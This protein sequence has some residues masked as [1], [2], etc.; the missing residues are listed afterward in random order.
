MFINYIPISLA[1][2]DEVP[3]T[4]KHNQAYCFVTGVEPSQKERDIS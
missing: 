2:T 3:S 1:A 4:D